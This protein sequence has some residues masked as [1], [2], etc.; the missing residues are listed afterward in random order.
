MY[1]TQRPPPDGAYRFVPH[2]YWAQWEPC[3]RKL[4]LD[5]WPRWEVAVTAPN[6][7][8]VVIEQIEWSPT[9]N[10]V[11]L[12]LSNQ[13][14]RLAGHHIDFIELD[15]GVSL[16]LDFDDAQSTVTGYGQTLSWEVCRQPWH[17]G[18]LLMLRIAKSATAASATVKP[19]CVDENAREVAPAPTVTPT[20]TPAR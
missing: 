11:A 12:K 19:I 17:P 3:N 9:Q 18:D 7:A 10:K 16:R 1:A 14:V 20:P 13:S 15:A 4:P 6:G 2:Q 5:D 8:N